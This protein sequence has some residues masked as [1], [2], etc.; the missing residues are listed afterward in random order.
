VAGQRVAINFSYFN[1]YYYEIAGTVVK[2]VLNIHNGNSISNPNIG[3]LTGDYSQRFS[4]VTN[5]FNV[6]SRAPFLSGNPVYPA[7]QIQDIYAPNLFTSTSA[8]G[9]ITLSFINSSSVQ[10]PG[11]V[12]NISLYKPADAL[13]CSIDITPTIPTI[14]SG[15]STTLNVNGAITTYPINNNFNNG[16]I[17]E[18]WSATSSASFQTNACGSSSI[19]NTTYLWMQNAPGPRR[20]ETNNFNLI[21]GGTISFEYRQ[22]S[23]NAQP[24][25]CEASDYNTAFTSLE[26]IYLQ[27]STDNGTT[28]QLIKYIFPSA[29]NI[30]SMN[31]CGNYVHNWTRMEYPIPDGAKTL[32]TRLR[33]IQIVATNSSTDNWGLDNVAISTTLN[34]NI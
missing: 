1:T 6:G 25:P 12:A 33:W 34:S 30:S 23:T 11:W 10:S 3:S 22:A 17:G 16:T 4:N 7:N 8:D 24:S 9:C 27:Y 2:D 32:N 20:L 29:D 15:E 19:D 14:C 26:G 31:G 13:G 21:N 5:P 28:W 18:G